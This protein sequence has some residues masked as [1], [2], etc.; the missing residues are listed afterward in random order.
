MHL[1]L[2]VLSMNKANKLNDLFIYLLISFVVISPYVFFRLI[3]NEKIVYT[4]SFYLIFLLITL[5][6]NLKKP[7]S[8]TL[9]SFIHVSNSINNLIYYILIFIFVI[10]TQNLYLNYETITWD[11]ASYLVA[12]LPLQDGYLPYETQWESK[13][14]LLTY[15][16]YFLILL[17]NKSLVFIKLLNDLILFIISILMFK[18]IG[19]IKKGEKLYSLTA[20]L[21][22]LSFVSEPQYISAYSELFVVLFISTAYYLYWKFKWENNNTFFIPLIIS[23]ASLI[24]Q[25]ALIFLLPYIFDVI[26]KKKLTLEIFRKSLFGFFLPHI[27]FQ[28]IYI[29]NNL[30]DIFITNYLIIPFGYSSDGFV[31][32]SYS[33]NELKVW[34]RDYFYYNKY[35]YFS[36]VTLLFYQLLQ[37]LK[38]KKALFK[39]LT[40]MNI[41]FALALY[42]IGGT[43]YSHH[44]FYF[45]FFI[46][47]LIVK[48][49]YNR[50]YIVVF[51]MIF[52]SASSIFYKSFPNASNN[53]ANLNDIQNNYPVY[54]LSQEIDSYF[55][56]DYSIFALE[57][58]L[59]LF[60][61]DKPNYSYIVHP[62]NHFEEYITSPLINF[63]RIRENNV[64]Y[65]LSTK[66]DVILCNSIR[67]FA[68]GAPTEN[69]DFD[70][71]YD[72]YKS[73]YIQ[74]DTSEYRSDR[75]IEFYYDP[76]KP[77]NVFIEK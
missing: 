57:Y 31:S 63:G 65:L 38:D 9:N 10:I 13:G 32:I 23:L 27:L 64:D 74:L 3:N 41:F 21:L 36:L 7:I 46:P 1:Y 45:I 20:T 15:I 66:P 39:D 33:L 60:Y 69:N 4:V 56:N 16:Y 52:L 18:T 40:F 50:S 26:Y 67:I 2:S 75:T 22:F 12:S 73:D 72:S 29:S 25:V 44:L 14:P 62:T 17:S 53:L 61:L 5:N 55:E 30:Y 37:I 8:K 28:G 19:L 71:S 47:F 49:N 48:L 42:F 43:N 70:C 6:S 24:N 76:Y 59:V 54:K 34:F 11:T 77:M 35:I 51:L 68:G 58:I